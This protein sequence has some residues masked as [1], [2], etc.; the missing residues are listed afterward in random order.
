M[1]VV[2]DNSLIWTICVAPHVFLSV[3]VSVSVYVSISVSVSV[4]ITLPVCECETFFGPKMHISEPELRRHG[5]WKCCWDSYSCIYNLYLVSC[6]C[7]NLRSVARRCWNVEIFMLIAWAGYPTRQLLHY[8]VLISI[9]NA[10]I[11]SHTVPINMCVCLCV[12]QAKPSRDE[13]AVVNVQAHSICSLCLYSS[14]WTSWLCHVIC[15][16]SA[17]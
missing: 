16:Y 10:C 12:D 15:I 6:V 5:K 2:L 8:Q 3:S 11:G 1:S 4:T 13:P 14:G 7:L 9:L 17:F